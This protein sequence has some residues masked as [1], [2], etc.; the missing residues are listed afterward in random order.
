MSVT[1]LHF[2]QQ[3]CWHNYKDVEK[4]WIWFVLDNDVFWKNFAP[5]AENRALYLAIENHQLLWVAFMINSKCIGELNELSLNIFDYSKKQYETKYNLIGSSKTTACC[6]V[7]KKLTI[8]LHF[9]KLRGVSQMVVGN[10][11]TSKFVLN[12]F[13]VPDRNISFPFRS[14]FLID[15]IKTDKHGKMPIFKT[16]P[17][18][19]QG[20]LVFFSIKTVA[21]VCSN[22]SNKDTH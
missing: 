17:I 6:N 3:K 15:L 22:S 8:S 4:I 10:K 9:F 20:K 18:L 5:K 11:V 13:N 12:V 7:R 14:R 16:Y 1:T 2:V 21:F 19:C